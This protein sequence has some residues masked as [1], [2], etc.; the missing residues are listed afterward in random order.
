MFNGDLS[1]GTANKH[2]LRKSVAKTQPFE[3][4][5]KRSRL[6]QNIEDVRLIRFI[7]T[8]VVMGTTGLIVYL[9][10]K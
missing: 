10:N 4:R 2:F 1:F 8:L 5:F 3:K 6:D 9:Y 7:Y